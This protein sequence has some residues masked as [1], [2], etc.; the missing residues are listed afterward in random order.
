MTYL[1]MQMLF[2]LF[3]AFLLGLLIGWL[4]CKLFCGGKKKSC[5]DGA[6]DVA[7]PAM[8]AAAVAPVMDIMEDDGEIDLD[9]A[10]D[11]DAEGYGIQ[12]LEGIGP[13]TGD[14]FRGYGVASVGDY[15]RKLYTPELREKAAKDL[16]IL[17]KPLHGWASM[18]D[19]LR[20]EGIDHQYAELT[21]AAGIE[22][23]QDLAAS[24]ADELAARMDSV[25]NAGKQ[26]I[27][28]TSPSASEV[29]GW[30][31]KAKTMSPVVT[32]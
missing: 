24:D 25:N 22:T 19:L 23:V 6:A 18:S 5:C 27:A 15:L 13:Q 16:D 2:C 28:P 32:M 11:L 30:I 20:V 21:S 29:A 31:A 9:T 1:I 26:L 8:G 14:L 4:L 10:V 7:V 3:I 12:T 17:V